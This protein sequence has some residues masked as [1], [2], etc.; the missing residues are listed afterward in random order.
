MFAVYAIRSQ[1]TERIYVG[2]TKDIN[3]RMKR[4]N[5]GRVKS[6]R[7]D[8]PR[9]LFAVEYFEDIL[10][11]E[12][13]C[14]G[15][16]VNMKTRTVTIQEVEQHPREFFDEVGN[17]EEIIVNADGQPIARIVP[18]VRRVPGLHQG[19]VRTSDD[20]DASLDGE[21]WVGAEAKE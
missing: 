14:V 18:P 7:K 2:Q 10:R 19:K 21:F 6:T 8:I 4:H 1:S 11:I 13:T 3:Q 20:F 9:R 16:S 17:G 15:G 12:I 5:N